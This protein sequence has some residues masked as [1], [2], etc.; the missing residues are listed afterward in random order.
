[1]SVY[2]E[3]GFDLTH[4]V[5]IDQTEGT[6]VE[7]IEGAEA[8][9]IICYQGHVAI[10]IGDGMIVHAAGEAKGIIISPACYDNIIT[11]RRMFTEQDN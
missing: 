2:K 1:M 8:G 4:S 3:F 5:E 9:D 7:T 6:A 10:Y 11:V